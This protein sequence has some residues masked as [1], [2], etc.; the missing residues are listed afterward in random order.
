M[1]E[2]A[3]TPVVRKL[4]QTLGKEERLSRKKLIEE[5]YSEG[6]SIKTPA[7]VL[8]YK[9]VELPTSFPAQAMFTASKRIFKRAH[10]RNRVKRLLREAYRKQKNVV[11]S[12]LSAGQKQAMLMFIF[13]GRQLPNYP[14]VHGKVLDLLKRFNIEITEE[15]KKSIQSS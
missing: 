8:L 3:S 10:D 12:S 2:K 4:S 1:T 6:K 13:T 15:L 14:Y 5:L 11:Y 7:I 9:F